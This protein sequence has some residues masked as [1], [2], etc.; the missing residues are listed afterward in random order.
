MKNIKTKEDIL[1]YIILGI[2]YIL[3]FLLIFEVQTITFPLFCWYLCIL[4]ILI[5]S[6]QTYSFALKKNYKPRHKRNR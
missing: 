2:I 5:L 6:I 1:K 4:S 3:I